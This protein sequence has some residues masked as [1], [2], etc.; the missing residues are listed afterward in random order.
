MIS[1]TFSDSSRTVP[2]SGPLTRNCTG[3]PTGGPF[4]SLLMRVRID[5]YSV[6]STSAKAAASRSRSCTLFAV[7]TNCAKFGVDSC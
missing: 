6:R 7:T 4:S 5:E 1:A 3:K 2:I